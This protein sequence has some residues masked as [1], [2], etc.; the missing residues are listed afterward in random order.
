MVEGCTNREIA[1][2]LYISVNT[3]KKHVNHIFSKLDVTNRGQ[4]IAQT[5]RL[6]LLS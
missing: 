1:G 3:V 4:A 5:R 2:Q 6:S